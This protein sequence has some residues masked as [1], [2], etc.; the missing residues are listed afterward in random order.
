MKLLPTMYVRLDREHPH[1]ILN[2][3][4]RI[5][6]NMMYLNSAM[7][8]KLFLH[9]KN[10]DRYVMW[11]IQD[12]QIVLFSCEIK[13]SKQKNTRNTKNHAFRSKEQKNL[14]IFCYYNS[15]TLT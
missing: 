7:N 15:E 13:S 4:T 3:Y 14:Q 8:M 12:D 10:N 5:E 11:I 9:N 2:E 1:F 6:G